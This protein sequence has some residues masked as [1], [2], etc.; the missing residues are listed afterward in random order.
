MKMS[1]EFAEPATGMPRKFRNCMW[2][3][4]PSGTGMSYDKDW[5][6]KVEGK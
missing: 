1:R 6:E 5:I 2:S 4:P 3:L